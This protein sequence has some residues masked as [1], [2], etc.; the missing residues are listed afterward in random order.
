MDRLKGKTVIVTGAGTGIGKAICQ[1]YARE[2]ADVAIIYST[3]RAGA[4][5]TRA[6][7]EAEGQRGILIACDLA[8][9]ED[10]QNVIQTTMDAFGRIDI[11]VNNAAARDARPIFE[12]DVETWDHCFDTNLRADFLMTKYAAPI[13][14]RQGGGHIINVGSI[15]ADRPSQS[16]R[17]AYASSKSAMVALTAALAEELGEDHIYVNAL[18][19]GSITTA[20]GGLNVLITDDI[21]KKRCENIPLR[22]R[23]MP[24]DLVGPAIFLACE[25]CSYVDGAVLHVDGGYL[26]AD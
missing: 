26:N 13:M 10:I 15:F 16:P 4:E 21:V 25:D 24:E 18:I 11:I 6:L 3:S 20:I 5:D 14:R 17:L 19:P 12:Y 7:V 23:G 9:P 2:G 22:R 8:K 1:G